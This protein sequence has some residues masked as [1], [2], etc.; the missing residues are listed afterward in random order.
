MIPE[1]TSVSIDEGAVLPSLTYRLKL[2]ESKIIGKID[3]LES[4]MQAVKLILTID[5]YA[6]PIYNGNYGNDILDLIGQSADYVIADLPRR[7]NEALLQDDR[8]IGTD[9]YVFTKISLDSLEVTFNV[10]TIFGTSNYT[11]E[12]AA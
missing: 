2:E 3:N 4:V 1:T 6:Y 9:N 12:V 11:L 10:N 5:R 7:V 8:I